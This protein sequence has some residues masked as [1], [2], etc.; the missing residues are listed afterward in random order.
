MLIAA[1]MCI[2]TNKNFVRDQIPKLEDGASSNQQPTS[3]YQTA[4]DSGNT[5]PAK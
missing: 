5:S 2:Y 1:D 3:F 4:K